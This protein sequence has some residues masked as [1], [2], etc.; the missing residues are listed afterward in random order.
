M[1]NNSSLPLTPT[2]KISQD[3]FSALPTMNQRDAGIPPAGSLYP[4]EEDD[5]P[6]NVLE[7]V[8]NWTIPNSI[9]TPGLPEWVEIAKCQQL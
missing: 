1:G 7:N 3:T 5:I 4:E 9:S 6:C 8:I 2:K